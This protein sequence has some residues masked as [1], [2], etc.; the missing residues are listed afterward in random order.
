MIRHLSH[1]R[2]GKILF[3]TEKTGKQEQEKERQK[4]NETIKNGST[5]P[6]DELRKGKNK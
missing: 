1:L 6:R 2:N 5:D 3:L 4:K